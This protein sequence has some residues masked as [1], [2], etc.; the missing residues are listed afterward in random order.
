MLGIN[1]FERAQLCFL[2]KTNVITTVRKQSLHHYSNNIDFQR[3]RKQQLTFCV[4]PATS[5]PCKSGHKVAR[6]LFLRC[7]KMMNWGNVMDDTSRQ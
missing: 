5:V 6:Q 3:P 4:Q 2:Y 1:M 7:V